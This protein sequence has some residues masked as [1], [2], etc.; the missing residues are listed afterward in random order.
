MFEL[1][2]L[3]G[4]NVPQLR[5]ARKT[6]G[7]SV[8]KLAERAGVSPSTILDIE[9]HRA[10]GSRLAKQS[11]TTT[12]LPTMLKIIVGLKGLSP[13]QYSIE[14]FV[15]GQTAFSLEELQA[16]GFGDVDSTKRLRV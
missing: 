6:A 5:Q 11:Q 16:A 3:Q 14:E 10:P 1:F 2:C 7:L 4:E 9:R 13:G 8:E 12:K 15:G